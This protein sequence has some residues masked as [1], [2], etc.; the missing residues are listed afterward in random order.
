[1]SLCMYKNLSDCDRNVCYPIQRADLMLDTPTPLPIRT[2]YILTPKSTLYSID[3]KINL[4]IKLIHDSMLRYIK[5]GA[6]AVI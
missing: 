1:M 4:H 6:P 5:D 2:Y 3:I